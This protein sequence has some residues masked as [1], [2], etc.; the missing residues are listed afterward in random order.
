MAHQARM[1]QALLRSAVRR[2]TETRRLIAADGWQ[3][4]GRARY[5]C[6]AG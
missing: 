2:Q 3:A 4:A 6:A 1:S 5:L